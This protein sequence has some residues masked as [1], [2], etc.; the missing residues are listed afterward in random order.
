MP[1]RAPAERAHEL[2]RGRL[3]LHRR[4]GAR[5]GEALPAV[6]EPHVP[7]RAARST[8]TSRPSSARIIEG[9]C[10]R[11]VA[12]LKERNAL[13]AVCGRVCP[14][15]EQCEAACVLA[16]KGEPVAIGR[17]ERFLGDYD[18]ACELEHR[19]V[20]E[21]GA[22]ERLARARSSAP[23]RPASRARASSRSSATRSPSSSRCTRPAACSPT[24]SPSSACPRTSSHA[25]IEM[26]AEI[27]VEIVTDIVVGQLVTVAELL[28]EEGFDAVFVGSGRG[29]AGLP[30]HP[31]REPQ[32][33]LLGQR[34][35]HAREPHAR[36]RVPDARHA[37]VA[38]P[39]GRGRRRRQRRD[40]LGAHG[41]APRRRGGLPRL[42]AH[43]RRDARAP[44]R[45]PPRARGGRRVQDA[46]LAGW[47]SSAATASSPASSRRAWSSASRTRAAGA[48]RCA[49]MDSEFT[50]DCDTVIS[51][52]GTRANPLLKQAAPGSRAHAARLQRL[53]YLLQSFAGAVA[54]AG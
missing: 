30:G 48:R 54:A 47:R 31:G 26:L 44:R 24:A 49:C 3:R 6:Q 35:P 33:R 5:R 50:I 45:G 34:V 46:L 52:V 2:R 19:C 12:V 22:A 40:G 25:E 1:E 27:G 18:L 28:A 23:A 21:V 39:Q 7:A 42:P 29:P 11:G 16:K 9:D 37:G 20:P 41:P 53:Q 4:D 43:R 51:A 10:P 13:P 14:Q 38:R 32:R 8:S 36:L 15:E 17:L